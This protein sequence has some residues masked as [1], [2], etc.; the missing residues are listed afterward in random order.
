M[1]HCQMSDIF[2]RAFNLVAL[3]GEIDEAQM[4]RIVEFASGVIRDFSTDK[5]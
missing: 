5:M 2:F 1:F 3:D 4:W